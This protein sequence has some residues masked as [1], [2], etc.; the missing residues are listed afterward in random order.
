MQKNDIVICAKEIYRYRA[1]LYIAR[2][3][4]VAER[5][6]SH[7]KTAVDLFNGLSRLTSKIFTVRK[8]TFFSETLVSL[9]YSPIVHHRF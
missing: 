7:F 2:V 8:K 3:G 1:N 4:G 9:A 5:L 6:S